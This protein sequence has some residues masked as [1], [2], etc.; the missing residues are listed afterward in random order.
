MGMSNLK[1]KK[2]SFAILDILRKYTDEDLVP[3]ED[4]D[5]E[6]IWCPVANRDLTEIDCIEICD[7]ANH[8]L[9][10]DVLN[11]FSPPIEWD[12]EKRTQCRCCPYHIGE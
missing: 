8:M 9:K 4:A 12:E 7:V 6:T 11:S 5:A 1:R 3:P 10:E 2:L